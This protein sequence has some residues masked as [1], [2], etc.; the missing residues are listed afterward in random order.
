MKLLKVT[1][2]RSPI[3]RQEKQKR[4]LKGLGLTKL[5]KTVYL[6][7]TEA[8]RGMVYK[9]RHLVDL[10]VVTE[11]QRDAELAARKAKPQTFRIVGEG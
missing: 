8:N 7:N 3:G 2:L 6:E 9:V 1:L 5:H 4:T 10:D 11:K